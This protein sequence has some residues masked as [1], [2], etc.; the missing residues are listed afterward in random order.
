MKNILLS[1]FILLMIS[2]VNAQS[3]PFNND[4]Q[5][6]QYLNGKTFY[7]SDNGLEIEYGYI[8]S[9][10]TLGIKVNNKYGV[11]FY[12]I[13]VNIKTYTNYADL[14]GMSAEN[15]SNF[16]F[17]LFKSKLVVGYGTGNESTYYLK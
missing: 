1:S 17:R 11:K 3:D 7:N 13:N 14:F 4:G 2:F 12:F 5:V 16:G 15:G 10:N 8:P 9:Y 6:I